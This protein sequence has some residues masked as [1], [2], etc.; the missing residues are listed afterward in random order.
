MAG[1]VLISTVPRAAEMDRSSGGATGGVAIM[2]ASTRAAAPAVA[3]T[4]PTALKDQ[5]ISDFGI[6]SSCKRQWNLNYRFLCITEYK[7]LQ[8]PIC[9]GG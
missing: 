6:K 3:K 2:T 8:S 9:G 5:R 7:S 1:K 4:H